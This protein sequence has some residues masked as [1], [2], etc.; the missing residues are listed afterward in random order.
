MVHAVTHFEIIC[1][2]HYDAVRDQVDFAITS[3]KSA[4][5]PTARSLLPCVWSS[6][7]LIPNVTVTEEELARLISY[8]IRHVFVLTARS[9]IQSASLLYEYISPGMSRDQFVRSICSGDCRLIAMEERLQVLE[10]RSS[11]ISAVA[12]LCLYGGLEFDEIALSLSCSTDAVQR[13]WGRVSPELSAAL[14]NSTLP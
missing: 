3:S 2:E 4:E 6:L 9:N 12:T 13:T 14:G 11:R 8:A 7:A 10:L 5:T 1:H